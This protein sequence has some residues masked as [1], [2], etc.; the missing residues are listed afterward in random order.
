MILAL[1]QRPMALIYL[2]ILERNFKKV[3]TQF[4]PNIGI[5]G[6]MYAIIHFH[7]FLRFD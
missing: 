6:K 1:F 4:L 3:F 5:T 7:G 2:L